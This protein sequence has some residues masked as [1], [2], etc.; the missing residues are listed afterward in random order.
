MILITCGFVGI[1]VLGVGSYKC[2]WVFCW[3]VGSF[4]WRNGCCDLMTCELEL[5]NGYVDRCTM[6]LFI[7][8]KMNGQGAYSW[9]CFFYSKCMLSLS[10]RIV[11]SILHVDNLHTKE[12]KNKQLLQGV[13]RHDLFPKKQ[14]C[15]IS[16]SFHARVVNELPWM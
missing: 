7:L 1:L 14:G 9:S 6:L 10:N 15:V 3:L 16:L 2:W 5:E 13:N 12:L 4:V 8:H 11:E